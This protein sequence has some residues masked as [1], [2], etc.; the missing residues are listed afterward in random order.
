MALVDEQPTN[1]HT[2]R[3]TLAVLM[4]TP[5]RRRAPI[6]TL[7]VALTGALA[8]FVLWPRPGANAAWGQVAGATDRQPLV[9]ERTILATRGKSREIAERWIKGD[10]WNWVAARGMFESG[11]DGSRMWRTF[12]GGT[13]PYGI[14]MTLEPNMVGSMVDALGRGTPTVEEFVRGKEY[15]TVGAPQPTR[16]P[17]GHRIRYRLERLSKEGSPTGEVIDVY[18]LPSETLIRRWELR[19]GQGGVDMYGLLD[20][21]GEISDAKFSPRFPAK[22]PVFDLDI[23][24]DRIVGT[25]RRGLGTQTIGGHTTTLRGVYLDTNDCL[26]VLWSGT[27]PNGDL[28]EPVRSPDLKVQRTFGLTA[29]TNKRLEYVPPVPPS[30]ILNESLGGMSLS[31]KAP[32]PSRVTLE[33]PVY[34]PDPSRPVIDFAGNSRGFRSRFVGYARFANVPILNVGPFYMH[35]D[36]L[37]LREPVAYERLVVERNLRRRAEAARRP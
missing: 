7:A 18:T 30:P 26:H 16:L 34:A 14:L 32:V 36:V 17:D 23:V 10:R 12:K 8:T 31:L 9:H 15:R 4:A 5:R 35:K 33:V 37:G 19:N 6:R 1:E 3:A 13:R 29:M 28:R 2:A 21:P 25:L 27:P 20:Y 24:K 22:L 11:F